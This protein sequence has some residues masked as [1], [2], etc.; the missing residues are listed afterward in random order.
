MNT[1]VTAF[2]SETTKTYTENGAVTY[3]TSDDALV[4]MFFKIGAMRGQSYEAIRNV[5]KPAFDANPATAARISLWLRDVRE[6][7]GE[8]QTFR[9][10]LRYLCE[11]NKAIILQIA[12]QILKLGRSDDLFTILDY[13]G[14]FV[15]VY[16]LNLI[17]DELNAENRLMSKWIPRKGK[18][19]KIIRDYAGK[20]EKEMRQLLV[21]LTNVVETKMCDKDWDQITYSHVP[22]VAMKKYSKAFS[23]N[24]ADRF[25]NYLESVKSGKVNKDT[26]KVEKINAGAI[27]PYDVLKASPEVANTMWESLPDFVPEGMS[28]LPIIDTSGSMSCSAGAGKTTCMDVAVS[29]GVYLAERNKSVFKDMWINFSSRPKVQYLKGKNILDKI[30]KLDYYDWMTSTNLEEAMKLILETAIKNKVP[31]EDMPDSLLILSDMEFDHWGN[32][33]PGKM[34]KKLFEDNGYKMPNIIWWNIQ[35]RNG[36]VPVKHNEHGMALVSGFSPSI[37]T[38][39]LAGD[40]TPY[41]IMMNTIMKDRYNF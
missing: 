20:T 5:I 11:E 23:R 24:D 2:K 26:G 36:V 33:A 1:L 18:Y 13:G 19:N 22:S 29:L 28:F 37:M 21:R 41:K 27:Y 8:R 32:E 16:C 34:T 14:V 9:H 3:S 31:Q 30:K 7:A 4:D 15:K 38:G 40:I 17:W 39:L 12:K 10:I 35:S 6:G 25:T